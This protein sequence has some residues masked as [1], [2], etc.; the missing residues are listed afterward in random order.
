MWIE[1]VTVGKTHGA[2]IPVSVGA[3]KC[4]ALIDTGA[5]RCCVSEQYFQQLKLPPPVPLCR[6]TVQNASR[7]SMRPLGMTKC[8]I[9]MGGKN[10]PGEFLVCK[11]L[12]RPCI[13]GTDLLKKNAIYVG[14]V[15]GENLI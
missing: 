8:Q 13:I 11:Y 15:N 14:W 12:K 4:N 10:Y 3:S 1:Q 6:V 5:M 7:D 2:T 9:T